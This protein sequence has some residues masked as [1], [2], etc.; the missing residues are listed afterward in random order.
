MINLF[1][2][3]E[4]FVVYELKCPEDDKQRRK[5]YNQLDKQ[6]IPAFEMGADDTQRR[7][8][9]GASGLVLCRR[10]RM[11]QAKRSSPVQTPPEVWGFR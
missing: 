6:R 9:G 1:I 2:Y 10:C 4:A 8:D 7:S 5:A 3:V 11:Y